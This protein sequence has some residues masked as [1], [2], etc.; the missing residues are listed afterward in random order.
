[1]LM[2]VHGSSYDLLNMS[3]YNGLLEACAGNIITSDT[4]EADTCRCPAFCQDSCSLQLTPSPIRLRPSDKESR[5]M[6]VMMMIDH[7]VKILCSQ[8]HRMEKESCYFVQQRYRYISVRAESELAT[9]RTSEWSLWSPVAGVSRVC[10]CAVVAA[11]EGSSALPRMAYRS[12]KTSRTET[13]SV[14]KI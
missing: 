14:Q 4:V 5:M 2:L 6:M 8:S 11:P 13:V 9:C 3:S 10:L 7:F 1:M 12:C